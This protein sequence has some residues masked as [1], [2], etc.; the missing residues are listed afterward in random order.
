MHED[1]HIES[2]A[3][4]CTA[5]SSRGIIMV[6]AKIKSFE[7]CANTLEMSRGN[8][9]IKSIR[10]AAAAI[11]F[12]IVLSFT[13][14]GASEIN[15]IK[16]ATVLPLSGPAALENYSSVEA[17]RLAIEELNRS[18]GILGRKLNLI[19]LD[20]RS[21]PLGSKR[22]AQKAADAGVSIVFGAIWSS[23]S[24]AAAPIL[25]KAGIPMLSSFSTHPK[26]TRIGNYIFRICY[27]DAFQG[28]VLARFSHNELRARRV[29]ILVN[30]S[31][32][33]SE[34][35]AAYFNSEFQELGG[36]VIFTDNYLEQTADFSDYLNRIKSFK[37]DVVFHPGHT[38]I[39]A[40][41]IKQARLNGIDTPF[42]GGDGWNDVMYKLVG[43]V[44]EGNYYVSHWH[45]EN[46][47]QPS[48]RFVEKYRR[49]NR[50]L[51]PG[52]A[53]AQDCVSLFADAA[54][55]AGSDDPAEIRDAIASTKR[56]EGITG[57]ISFDDHGDPVKS[58]VILRFERG[59]S[60]YVKSVVP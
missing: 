28:R 24:M 21:T 3:K 36:E 29:G 45:V 44:I 31:S 7:F 15:P 46:P 53:L 52:S 59:S 16:V 5:G 54:R 48:L 40:I 57:T 27:T 11:Y 32:A 55:R 17:F 23:N 37:P 13:N 25:Q 14:L 34:G 1:R 4:Y 39:S 50:F 9:L 51:D 43:D 6:S 47:R 33:Y 41:I 30:A 49:I 35:L 60:V 42:I 10:L 38:R 2:S 20:N 26:L 22:A 58:A 8:M 19:E 18:G 56:F 12:T